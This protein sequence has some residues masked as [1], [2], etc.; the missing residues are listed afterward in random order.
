MK[1]LILLALS[2]FYSCNE[3]KIG[4]SL[5]SSSSST[6]LGSV[7]E[8]VP[9][10]V[11]DRY[12]EVS[13]YSQKFLKNSR[14]RHTATLLDNGKVLVV[15]G[16]SDSSTLASAE[17]Y[18]PETR[19]FT[20]TGS[21]RFPRFSHTATRLEDGRVLV[22]GGWNPNGIT[23][24][25]TSVEIYDP[26][27]NAFSAGPS[28][29]QGRVSH[30]A[31]L[32]NDGRVL[33][34]GGNYIENNR[35]VLATTAEIYDPNTNSFSQIPMLNPRYNHTATLLKDG[36]VLIAA[37]YASVNSPVSQSLDIFDPVSNTFTEASSLAVGRQEHTATLL[38]D[39]RVLIAGGRQTFGLTS[40]EIYNPITDT[41]VA[42]GSLNDRKEK[43]TATLLNDGR[44][45]IV[46]D[47]FETRNTIEI[48]DPI[49]NL[50][51]LP[52]TL[53][54]ERESH[55]A[56]LLKDGKVVIIGG[57][58]GNGTYDYLTSAE[59]FD[60][61]TNSVSSEISKEARE[62]HT[63]SVLSDGKIAIFGGYGNQARFL[64]SVLIFDPISN[65]FY[66]SFPL[67]NARSDHTTTVL[68]DGRLLVVGG[69]G[70]RVTLNSVE[71]YDLDSG[72]SDAASLTL[73]R[74][75]H[76]ATLLKNGKVLIVGGYNASNSGGPYLSSAEVY[77]PATNTFSSAGSLSEG[78][79]N[80]TATLLND[81]RVLITGGYIGSREA[82]S[83]VELYDPS[84]NTFVSVQSLSGA[85]YSHT[86]TL[87]NDGKVLI[88][89]GRGTGFGVMQSTS[90]IYDPESGVFS[91]SA[92]LSEARTNHTAT[93][94]KDGNVLISGGDSG[95]TDS[96][97]SVVV[98]NTSLGTFTE[99]AP[100]NVARYDHTA[101]LLDDG[102]VFIFGGHGTGGITGSW[103]FRK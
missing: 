56:T 43:H 89:G 90:E 21:L 8:E 79:S 58:R 6:N 33:I 39:G 2:L 61:E 50:F 47:R 68:N 37:G 29:S 51:S 48:Y 22:A 34:L 103:D 100:L 72:S 16:Y 5:F 65:Q 11:L 30:T 96:S 85:R 9:L 75:Q 71:I 99:R 54:N 24:G 4:S 42:A 25:R 64:D 7:S 98:Y 53:V 1:F 83:S 18:D 55:T 66:N 17:L 84:S 59:T 63:A 14:D 74:T 36:K 69:R 97:G 95:S 32:L 3:A 70:A 76:T 94:L 44:V 73:G 91:N 10:E 28:L 13:K 67:K 26:V 23:R 82:L 12:E 81:G 77:D 35:S 27:S 88:V 20:E 41:V 102:E 93:L 31:T 40:A 46:G 62:R 86:A 78:R 19:N 45:L 80:H 38:K 92:S 101:V 57:A 49:T 52:T 87:L 60:P 15:G